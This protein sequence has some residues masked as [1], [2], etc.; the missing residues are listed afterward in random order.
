MINSK[1]K[2]FTIVELVI[3]IAVVAVLAAV[4]IP[5]FSNLVKKANISADQQAVVQM[6]KI[7][8][9]EQAS[10]NKPE[11]A[12]QALNIL[13]ENGYNYSMDPYYSEY[14]LAWLK[15]ENCVV[16]IQNDK[17]VY[18][19]QYVNVAN[20]N[21]FVAVENDASKLQAAI[22]NLK[23]GEVLVITEDITSTSTLSF[24]F[25]N[26][27]SYGLDF[28]GNT[29]SS[30]HPILEDSVIGNVFKNVTEISNGN[31][32]LSNGSIVAKNEE[33]NTCLYVTEAASVTV[34]NMIFDNEGRLGKTCVIS[35]ACTELMTIT[36]CIVKGS[37]NAIQA[38]ESKIVL[39]NVTATSKNEREDNDFQNAAIGLGTSFDLSDTSHAFVTVNGGTYS[40]KYFVSAF[41]SKPKEGYLHKLVINDGTFNGN[42]FSPDY[43]DMK[44]YAGTFNVT[45]DASIAKVKDSVQPGCT[46][47]LNGEKFSK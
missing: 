32:L 41:G 35:T 21:L 45:D 3:V 29:L 12:I 5:T 9:V 44:I 2:G 34:E 16:L 22:E 27:G 11:T 7:L 4:L 39:N 1:K 24:D 13:H 33:T 28:S 23:A 43:I 37:G 46:I 30:T 17:I 19:E 25:A 10:G 18:P 42:I 38:Y 47:T 8:S 6:N 26:E 36:N 15:E 31:V 20:Y 40:A 14:T